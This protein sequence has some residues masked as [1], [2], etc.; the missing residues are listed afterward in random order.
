MKKLKMKS[1]INRK[2]VDINVWSAYLLNGSTGP[3]DGVPG[4]KTTNDIKPE[5]RHEPILPYSTFA[6]TLMNVSGGSQ[7]DADLLWLSTGKYPKNTIVESTTQEGKYRV[8][9]YSNYQDYSDVVIYELK[10]DDLNQSI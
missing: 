8:V 2:G 5:H 7:S 10:G 6:Q 1:L 9:N 4:Q 3:I